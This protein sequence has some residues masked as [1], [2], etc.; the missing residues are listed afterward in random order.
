MST[1]TTDLHVYF[2]VVLLPFHLS[3]QWTDSNH[4]IVCIIFLFALLLYHSQF[5]FNYIRTNQLNELKWSTFCG[6]QTSEVGHLKLSSKQKNNISN[7][8]NQASSSELISFILK[9][10]HSHWMCNIQVHSTI[11]YKNE[12]Q[13]KRSHDIKL[14]RFDGCHSKTITNQQIIVHFLISGN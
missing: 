4:L 5:S 9:Y 12:S 10:H 3:S 7:E 14:N 2:D 6:S 11:V 1:F 8:S 13:A